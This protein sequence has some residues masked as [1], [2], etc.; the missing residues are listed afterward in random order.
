[1]RSE[2]LARP[3]LEPAGRYTA[4]VRGGFRLGL[5]H[6]VA[7]VA[8]ALVLNAQFTW[9]VYYSLRDNR[10]RLDLERGIV[11]ARAEGAAL[12]LTVHAQQ[13][14]LQVVALPP[15]VI[16]SPTPPFVDVQVVDTR[17]L[18][19]AAPTTHGEAAPAPMGWVVKDGRPAFARPMGR[20]R[21]ALAFLDPQAPYRWLAEFD[22]TLQLVDRDAVLEGR[23]QAT[24]EAPFDHL[25]V[26]ADFH[27]WEQLVDRYRQ[28]VVGVLAEGAFF[29][30]AI[31]TAVVLLWRVL[32]RES[33]L[34]RQHQ[35][36]VSAVT[37]ELK[38][39]IAGIRLALETVLSGRVD[40]EGRTRFLNNALADS[41]R[42][43]DLVEK[44]LEVTRYAGG[45]R[46]LRM[47]LADVSQLVEDE[48]QAAE[49][50]V[51]ARGGV[52]D[53]DVTAGVQA[54]FD[55]EAMA[56]VISNL[57]ENALKYA[58]SDAPRVRVR[59]GLEQGE[60]VLEVCDNGVGIAAS[61]L[62]SIFKPFYR[63]GDEVIRRTPGTGIGLYLCREIVSA[64]GGKLIATSAGAGK[65]SVFRLTLP[66][67]EV[68][69]E[70]EFS[71]YIGDH[72]AR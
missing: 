38:T 11:V 25:V 34:E 6:L 49:R 21:V 39:P 5:G 71:E 26:T 13:A 16:P 29:L 19:G 64:H 3:G 32:R 9:W 44:V 7:F 35:N 31:V 72:E 51:A 23:P 20:D 36:F 61:E 62:E 10:E 30:A 65:G 40:G 58:G 59:L 53:A 1:L 48:V 37:H 63:A 46:R 70:D 56:I 60:A 66:G 8:V 42:L 57:I 28:R 12:R 55:P 2:G 17:E 67:A 22:P 27:R 15:G 24:P 45:T 14:A 43:G 4:P 18:P 54:T 68:L 50:R 52:L 33:S 69:P 41:E 47:G